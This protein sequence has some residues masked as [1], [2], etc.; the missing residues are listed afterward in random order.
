MIEEIQNIESVPELRF[1]EFYGEW[2]EKKLGDVF[3]ISAG[4]DID[5]IHVSETK[6]YVFKYPIYANTEKRKGLYGYSDIFKIN[7]GVITVAGRGNIGIAHARNHKFYPIVRLL[8][9]KP[10]YI[11]NIFSFEYIINKLC[12]FNES[13]G[14]PQLTAPQIS[15]YK[16]FYPLYL[17]QKKIA[18]FLMQVDKRIDKLEEK[19]VKLGEYKKGVMQKI[20]SQEIRFKDDNGED[21][22]DW[23]KKRLGDIAMSMTMGQS[24]NSINYTDN[25]K[26]KILIQGNADIKRGKVVPRI[27]TREIT[28]VCEKGDIII[29]V[30]APVGDLAIS[31]FD[32]CIGRGVCAVKGNMF[33]FY[34]LENCKIENVWT[35]YSQGSTFAAISSVDLKS[36]KIT[37]P[38][39]EEQYKIANFLTSI[40]KHIEKISSQIENSKIFKNGLLQKMFV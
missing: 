34:I 26:D 17:E 13:T 15:T 23:E 16:V 1:P 8:V 36:L 25:K 4:G 33:L 30:R 10:K 39:E 6:N 31:A 27:Y 20:F 28:K 12:I 9:L 5:K 2:V 24:P 32:A 38:I 40:D 19:K 3:E 11:L 37:I 35:K 18:N 14:V 7:E 21:F 22:P 29:T